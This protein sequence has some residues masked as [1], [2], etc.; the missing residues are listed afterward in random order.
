MC[1]AGEQDGWILLTAPT[2]T[3]KCH[4]RSQMSGAVF[5]FQIKCLCGIKS[6]LKNYDFFFSVTDISGSLCRYCFFNLPLGHCLSMISLP[7][8]GLHFPSI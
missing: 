7:D 2:P 8:L 1:P 5:Y 4:P 6:V 3:F